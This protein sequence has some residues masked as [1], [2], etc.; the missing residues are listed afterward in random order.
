[1]VAFSLRDS[2]VLGTLAV[3]VAA[4]GGTV[5]WLKLRHKPTPEEIERERRAQLVR[6]GRI[7]D[8]TILDV[9]ESELHD[10]T[11][12]ISYTYEIGGVEYEC[13]QDITSLRDTIKSDDLRPGFPCSVRYDFRRPE[14]S[15]VLAE[16]W[17]GL[18]ATARSVPFD[19]M[20]HGR[21][22]RGPASVTHL[23]RRD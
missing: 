7:M 4:V 17:S 21:R 2:H 14:N 1:M 15:I 18:R 22:P 9:R 8:G 19:K 20:P 3:C 10:G 6:I 11:Q 23:P 13:S 12:F 16:N 5:A